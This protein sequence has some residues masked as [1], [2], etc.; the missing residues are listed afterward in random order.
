MRH[1]D[2]P[3]H[4][5]RGEL[6]YMPIVPYHLQQHQRP[7][8]PKRWYQRSI[9]YHHTSLVLQVFNGCPNL[10]RVPQ[11]DYIN[12][13][14][15]TSKRKIHQYGM[16]HTHLSSSSG[17]MVNPSSIALVSLN[18]LNPGT[19]SFFILSSSH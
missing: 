6:A 17:S 2:I 4:G 14:K 11:I 15:R 7:L 19:R 5:I 10:P 1:I 13:I 8:R 12:H 3:L 9:P 16:M 18:E